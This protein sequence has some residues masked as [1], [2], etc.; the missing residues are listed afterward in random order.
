MRIGLVNQSTHVSVQQLHQMA[1]AIRL[2]VDQ[3]LCPPWERS[4]PTIAIYRTVAAIPATTWPI[5]LMDTIADQPE[6][7][8]GFHTEDKGG[9]L[10]GIVAVEPELDAGGEILTGDWSVCSVLS[11]EILEMIIDPN[12]Q[13]WASDAS[14]RLYS[15]E[16]CDPVEGPTYVKDGCSVANFVLPAWFDPLAAD[17]AKH[18]HL[19]LLTKPFS[20]LSTGYVVYMSAGVVH[21][22]GG[23]DAPEHRI[24]LKEREASRLSQYAMS[25]HYIARPEA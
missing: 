7:V 1:Q 14:R 18:D 6:G 5:V 8:L 25:M 9:K 21:Q 10:S 11:H 16:T 19:G 20:H 2:Q 22:V 23:E 17:N 4:F 3:D 12:C 24:A 15:F 13:L